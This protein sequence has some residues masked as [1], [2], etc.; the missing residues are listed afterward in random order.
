MRSLIGVSAAV[1]AIAAA[2]PL[3]AQDGA[4]T[5]GA[6]VLQL[7]AGSRAPALSGAYAG[8]SGDAD[9][10]FYNPAGVASVAAAAS[11]AYQRHVEDIGL[12]SA[13]GAFR[14]GRLVFGASLLVLD[15]G[16]IAEVVPDDDFGGQTGRVTGNT[17]GASELAARAAVALPL[18]DDRLHVGL[19]AGM[20]ST[21]LA[22]LRR[23]APFLDA[24]VQYL[25]S[26]VTVGA[27][28]R[29]LGGSMSG[30][31]LAEA[32]LPTEL[33]AGAVV[34]VS[35]RQ[36]LGALIAADLVT[37]LEEGTTG[38]VAGVEAGLM[39][40][41]AGALGAVGRIGYDTAPGGNGLGALRLGGGISLAGVAFDYTYQKYDFFG[42]I[43]RFGVRWSRIP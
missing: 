38:V 37:S 9:A 17:L 36:G 14:A 16:D 19:T 31:G 43:H 27:S 28:I 8:M 25:L 5:A 23:S 35:G 34:D 15:F 42:T 3:A 10:L 32:P 18:V 4:G 6:T 11:L 1:F 26:R 24:G 33:R 29:N 41:A 20:V 21:D 30:S 22:G 13:A 39:P 40:S 12:I 7:P 2:T